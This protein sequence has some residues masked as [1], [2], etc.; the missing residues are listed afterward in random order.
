MTAPRSHLL[1]A[2]HVCIVYI[3]YEIAKYST[4]RTICVHLQYSL[5]SA[6]KIFS[7]ICIH[8]F[9]AHCRRLASIFLPLIYVVYGHKVTAHE[10]QHKFHLV[11][12]T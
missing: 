6:L 11:S 4:L 12:F 1:L 10:A 3:H 2:P 8:I 7:N 5:G 9:F